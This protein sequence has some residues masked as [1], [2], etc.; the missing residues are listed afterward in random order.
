[1]FRKGLKELD[2]GPYVLGAYTYGTVI[3]LTL[4]SDS[5]RKCTGVNIAGVVMSGDAVTLN[6]GLEIYYDSCVVS[7]SL[8]SLGLQDDQLATTLNI[9]DLPMVTSPILPFCI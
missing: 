1:M 2:L 6:G 8:S 7:E 9:R 5:W 4:M 3:A